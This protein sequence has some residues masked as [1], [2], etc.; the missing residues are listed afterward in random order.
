M[1]IV[2]YSEV[3]WNYLRTRKQN[4][5][6]HFPLN[7]RIL[8]FQP[9]SFVKRN[10]FFPR[11][12]GDI[13][14]LT[15]P[16]YRKSSYKFIDTLMSFHIFRKIFYKFVKWYANAWIII[17][18]KKRP[19]CICISNIYYLPLINNIKS[20][21]IWDFNDHPGQFGEIP[22]WANQEFTEFLIDKN[23]TIIS[24]SI[25]ITNYLKNKYE[26]SAYTIPNGVDLAKFDKKISKND[27]NQKPVIGYVGIIS[28]WFFDFELVKQ[29][30][31]HLSLYEIHLYGP[32]VSDVKEQ[33][34]EILRISNI[35]YFGE[36]PYDM[37]PKV[38]ETFTVGIIP[39]YSIP[40]VWRLASGKFLQY[41][42]IGIPVVSVWMDQYSK[43]KNN[44]FL[45]KTHSEFIDSLEKALKHSFIPMADELKGYDWRYLSIEFR[46]ELEAAIESFS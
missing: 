25:G 29:V 7:D 32:C 45:A 17:L 3:K 8:F 6:T 5:L 2:W 34:D 42:G 35:S 10:Y 28:S 46:N 4:L 31:T 19:D 26:R 38:M 12:E 1:N 27:L 43:I 33:L 18:L 37:L 11:K 21:V 39:L 40:E 13:Y 22:I 24:S 16:T 44:V 20:P 30:A 15:L 41:L 14:Y 23:N 9:F 36:K